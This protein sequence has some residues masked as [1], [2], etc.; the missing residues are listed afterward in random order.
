MA[1]YVFTCGPSLMR[2]NDETLK[3]SCLHALRALEHPRWE[4]FHY[5]QLDGIKNIFHWLGDGQTY[6]E[7]TMVGDRECSCLLG[8]LSSKR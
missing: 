7:K 4:D 8:F 5:E 2:T 3:G 1:R 6:N